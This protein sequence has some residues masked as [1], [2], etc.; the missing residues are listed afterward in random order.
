M[1]NSNR[2]AGERRRIG[3]KAKERHI[4]CCVAR[5]QEMHSHQRYIHRQE[6]QDIC[7]G[8][9]GVPRGSQAE[10]G[11]N[12][13]THRSD[14]KVS[15]V[16]GEVESSPNFDQVGGTKTNGRRNDV[17][18]KRCIAAT[19]KLRH[20]PERQNCCICKE[21]RTVGPCSNLLYNTLLRTASHRW[22]KMKQ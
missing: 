2:R 15:V 20:Q 4:M 7:N 18:K 3:G 21:W 14:P 12:N 10:S 22:K 17:R 19:Q 8:R 1:T 13:A 5:T 6:R 16:H 11:R 9:G